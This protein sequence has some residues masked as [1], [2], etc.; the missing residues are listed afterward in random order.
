M[1]SGTSGASQAGRQG[2]T[3][4][5]VVRSP[6]PMPDDFRSWLSQGRIPPQRDDAETLRIAAGVSCFETFEQ[7]QQ[8]ALRFRR[9]GRFVAEIFIPDDG[10]AIEVAR[11][12][13]TPGHHTVW[14]SPAYLVS[15]IVSVTPV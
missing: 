7:A 12:N 11:T 5:H 9:M 14:A 4:F 10:C 8:M 13:P 2:R 1:E 15:R 6:S 3:L